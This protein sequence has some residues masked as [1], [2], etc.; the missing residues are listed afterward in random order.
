M[1][2]KAPV[3]QIQIFQCQNSPIITG[4][5]IVSVKEPDNGRNDW[6]E[7]D[8]LDASGPNDNHY[9]LNSE[10]GEIIFGDGINGGSRLRG[11]R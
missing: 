11:P 8:D 2:R 7:K 9:I 4:T 5:Q 10:E 3:C 1:K 6:I